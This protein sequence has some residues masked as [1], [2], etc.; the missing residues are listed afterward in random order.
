MSKKY[1]DEYNREFASL[2]EKYEKLF[3]A[4]AD[5]TKAHLLTV[6]SQILGEDYVEAISCAQKLAARYK[7]LINIAFEYAVQGDGR[8]I[9]AEISSFSEDKKDYK[10]KS[11]TIYKLLDR[12][13]ELLELDYPDIVSLIR[14]VQY[15]M[16]ENDEKLS[17]MTKANEKALK[18]GREE[19]KSGFRKKLEKLLYDFACEINELKEK[20]NI[21]AS[22]GLSPATCEIIQPD[23]PD[24]DINFSD[25]FFIPF[26]KGKGTIN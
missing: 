21:T 20:Y 1:P 25:E 4:V 22:D 12:I 17:A 13:L 26:K 9:V 19:V 5:E 16:A 6:Y 8:E 3:K 11:E 23:Y 15:E 24:E 18:I 2:K 10:D 7:E 14:R